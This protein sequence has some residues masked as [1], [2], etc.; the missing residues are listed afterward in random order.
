MLHDWALSTTFRGQSAGQIPPPG[1]P[2]FLR[3][4][5]A[6]EDSEPTPGIG[7][8]PKPPGQTY[9]A[10]RV[11]FEPLPPPGLPFLKYRPISYEKSVANHYE[12]GSLLK[13][14]EQALP[15]LGKT[16]D[17]VTIEDLA[18]VDEFHVGGR[19]ATLHL[20]GQLGFDKSS[21]ILDVGCGLGGAARFVASTCAGRVTGI[22]LTPEY[23]ST[24]RALCGWL[25]LDTRVTLEQ[26]SALAMPFGDATF[27]GGYMLHVGM[28]IE[29]KAALFSEVFRTLKPGAAFGVFDI[30]RDQ[31][32]DLLY[33]VP[34]ATEAS[35]SHLATPADYRAALTSAG[36]EV[37]TETSRRDFTLDFFQQ[38]QARAAKSGGPPPLGLHTLMQASTQAKI[39][40][41]IGNIAGELLA[42]VELIARKP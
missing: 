37:T 32:G 27:D 21:H 26:G 14:I 20:I 40:N 4:L 39:K 38:V 25:G 30:M 8:P 10:V 15:N 3:S 35:T 9:P 12:H 31:N 17:T 22:D 1:L 6:C 7:P 2:I 28:N 29:D 42:P 36:F 16:T 23:I 41:M 11:P 34:W 19:P 18:P 5:D 13:S 33:P 24:G